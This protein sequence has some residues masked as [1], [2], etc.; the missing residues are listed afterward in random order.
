MKCHYEVLGVPFDVGDEELKKSYKKLALKWHPDKNPENITESTI[1]FRCI[2]Q[3]YEVLSD[4]QER[5]WY[6][7]HRDAILHGGLGKGDFEDN[8][9]NIF[10]FFNSSCYS[11][12]G[13]DENGFYSVYRNVFDILAEEDYN[14]MENKDPDMKIPSFGRSDSNFD[15]VV[16]V[17]YGYWSSYCTAKSYVWVEKFD[18]R[19]APERRT[20]RLMEAENKKLRDAA[21]KE[22]NE[23]IRQLVAFV[24]KR[25]KRVKAHKEELE[26]RALEL[27]QKSEEMR[28]KQVRERLKLLENY[29]EPE[30]SATSKVEKEIKEL[31]SLHQK[32]FGDKFSEDLSSEEDPDYAGDLFCVACNKAFK[33]DKAF[34]NHER[35]KKH[36]E[37]VI[38]LKQEMEEDEAAMVNSM[39][40][41]KN[42]SS[43][44][45][46]DIPVDDEDLDLNSDDIVEETSERKQKMSKKQKK[47]KKQQRL[48]AQKN[49][50]D[51][52]SGDKKKEQKKVEEASKLA[53]DF[54]GKVR[55]NEKDVI[56]NNH[57]EEQK[58]VIK[59]FENLVEESVSKK[60]DG[61]TLQNKEN[62]TEESTTN[63]TEES[64]TNATEEKT[65]QND[66]ALHFCNVCGKDYPSRNKLFDHLKETGHQSRLTKNAAT[67]VQGKSSKKTKKKEKR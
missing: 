65:M 38:L 56:I 13:D 42:D 30:W 57:P 12:Y 48:L 45:L 39:T 27:A 20:R 25:D 1:Q 60:S 31:E 63:V 59:T 26:R 64:T 44:A 8:S 35:S 3:A 28:K 18:T 47:K 41:K 10:Q 52:D 16:N 54:E 17:F 62:I 15:E 29:Q 36:K 5:A 34:A 49:D 6:D 22:R 61:Q 67:T 37:N 7:K 11:G 46:S 51:S 53:Q 58:K 33:S 66:T 9:L 21:K 40:E 24:K 43:E 14:Y 19:E 50:D 32:E 55:V 2:K 23:E 4:P